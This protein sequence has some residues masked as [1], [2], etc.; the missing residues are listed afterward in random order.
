[1][2]LRDIEV[3]DFEPLV[4]IYLSD[5]VNIHTLFLFSLTVAVFELVNVKCKLFILI[6]DYH[7]RE[8]F[9]CLVHISGTRNF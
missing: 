4:R 1:M 2:F 6:W 5:G 8:I 9:E 7:L 3:Q